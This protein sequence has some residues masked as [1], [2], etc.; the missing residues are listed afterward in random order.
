[1]NGEARKTALVLMGGGA[2]AAYQVGVLKGLA[3]L[4]P[5][6]AACPFAVITGTSAG[7]VSAAALAADA[8]HF[9]R[10]VHA[11]ERVWRDFRVHQVF[12]ADA[13]SM[14]RSGLHWLGALGSGGTLV[15]APHALFDNSPLW[16]LLR[17]RLD[18]DDIRR[19][20]RRGWLQAIGISATNYGEAESVTFFD[21]NPAIDPWRRSN[22][23]GRRVRLTL[24]HLMASLSLPFLFRPILLEGQYYG[25]GAM[26]QT[27]PLG[28][29]FQLGAERILT[30]G[31]GSADAGRS[32]ARSEPT[33]GKMFGFMLDSLFMDQ[34]DADIERIGLYNEIPGRRPVEVLI[35]NPSGDLTA[36]ARRHAAELPRSMR[37]LLRTVGANDAAGAELL[38]YLM[39]ERGFTR[40]LI[41]MGYT[42]AMARAAELRAFVAP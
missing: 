32:Q 14:L 29:A 26:R 25:D 40:E 20:V 30:I 36:A 35:V 22:R 13:A 6:G 2:R 38:S 42:D 37:M 34:I 1:L 3:G 31:V 10:A 27:S 24:E 5:R 19:S 33:F 9:L 18:F 17:E 16:D 23:S 11:I 28:P 7:A 4:L 21:A 15:R 8:A 41:A 12:K 39:F